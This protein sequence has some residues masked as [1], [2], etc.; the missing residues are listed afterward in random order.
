MRNFT[1]YYNNVM[2][3]RYWIGTIPIGNWIFPCPLPDTIA[4]IKGQEE[5]GG[6]TSYHHVQL[7]VLWKRGVRLAAV[8]RMFPGHWEP[9]KSNAAMAYVWKED[10]RVPNT[11]FEIGTIPV[12][13]NSPKD[14]DAVWVSA[15]SGNLDAIPADIRI[16]CYNQLKR[17]RTDHLVAPAIERSCFV[18]HGPTAT[19]KTRR[20]WEEAGMEAYPKDPRTKWWDSYRG[21]KHVIVDEYRG[22]IDIAHLLRWLDRYPVFVETKG[23]TE[24]LLAV[25]FWFTS[26]IHPQLWYPELDDRT[27]LALERR[28]NIIE[29]S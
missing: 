20:A 14:W 13:R 26:N 15:S 7:V 6:T 23:S 1:N 11:Q 4:Y 2:Q 29:I 28:L 25:T 5:S 27:W 16:R 8:R 19:G 22:A 9:T 10:T 24:P 18:F 17:I 12:N 3:A 21:Q